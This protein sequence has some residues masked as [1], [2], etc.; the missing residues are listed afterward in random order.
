MITEP[1]LN[2]K[3]IFFN[4]YLYFVRL[5]NGENQKV[6]RLGDMVSNKVSRYLPG[7]TIHH[8]VYFPDSIATEYLKKTD[9]VNNY[10]LLSDIVKSRKST[11]H[12]ENHELVVH[13]RLGDVIDN[14]YHTVENISEQ[15]NL[16]VKPLSYYDDI[17]KKIDGIDKVVIVT[18]FHESIDT[19]KSEQY[20]EKIENLI[21]RYGFDV[22]KRV[23]NDPDEDF[24]FMCNA[25]LFSPSAGGFSNLVK[26]IVSLKGGHIVE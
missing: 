10:R 4:S 21:K 9:K 19:S 14:D 5:F 23:N 12:P 26:N 16:Y 25:S 6:Y 24:I 13:V 22:T 15:G 11:K 8:C 3:K 20:L 7:G 18:G 17:L 1:T 2:V